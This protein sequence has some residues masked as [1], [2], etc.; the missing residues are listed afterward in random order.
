MES[1]QGVNY[2]SD[3]TKEE[4]IA[5]EAKISKAIAS[6]KGPYKVA[7]LNGHE[8]TILELP[9]SVLEALAHAM[10]LQAHS[11]YG[12]TLGTAKDP[13]ETDSLHTDQGKIDRLIARGPGLTTQQAANLLGVSRP[14]II[15]CVDQ[16]ELDHVKVGRYRRIEEG[17]F[18][19][20]A[21]QRFNMDL[22]KHLHPGEDPS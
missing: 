8:T 15:K 22:G 14:F 11:G 5:L 7:L 2:L 6:S 10:Q 13:R 17:S 1:A 21:Q 3:V 4:A 19:Q 20:F 16:G 12:I 9:R 18:L